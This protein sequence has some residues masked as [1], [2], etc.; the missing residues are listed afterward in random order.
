[1]SW[2]YRQN[3]GALVN[4]T[5]SVIAFGYSG[6]AEG[7]NNAALQ[8]TRDIGPIPCG[9]WTLGAPAD[10]PALG[11]YAIPLAADAMT[12]TFGRSGFFVHGDLK[13]AASHPHEASHGCV[14]L[15]RLIRMAMWTSG[16]HRLQVVP[17]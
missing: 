17:G 14:I 9:G 2:T 3:S 7:V 8:E 6:H 10:H 5:G 15:P 12:D 11:P 16:D 1:M 13:D 4:P